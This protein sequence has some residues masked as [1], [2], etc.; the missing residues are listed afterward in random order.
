MVGHCSTHWECRGGKKKIFVFMEHW[1]S[2]YNKQNHLKKFI[3]SGSSRISIKAKSLFGHS[4]TGRELGCREACH[5]PG[6]FCL[7]NALCLRLVALGKADRDRLRFL[8]FPMRQLSGLCGS[9]KVIWFSDSILLFLL[10]YKFIVWEK[11]LGIISDVEILEKA[12][13]IYLLEQYFST[14]ES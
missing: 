13:R 11:L 4:L 9:L 12:L 14:F 10:G 5:P 1:R 6:C 8:S 2:G 3:I 7:A